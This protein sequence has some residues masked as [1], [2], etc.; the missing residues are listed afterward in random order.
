[1]HDNGHPHSAAITRQFL[2]TNNVDALDWPANCPDLNPIEQVWNTVNDIAAAVQAE[3]A[4]SP[5]PFIQRTLT[6]YAVVSQRTLHKMVD[7]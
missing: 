7:T 4:H 5:V 2:T 6:A 1:M 3:R